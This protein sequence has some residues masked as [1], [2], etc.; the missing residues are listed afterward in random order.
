MTVIP[1]TD[2]SINYSRQPQ[3]AQVSTATAFVAG[4]AQKG[5]GD[6]CSV[7][8][9]V[10]ERVGRAARRPP[11]VQR[12]RV[13]RGGVRVQRRVSQL[14]FARYAGPSAAIASVAV[15]ASSSKFTASAKGPGDY[16]HTIY[17]GVA[18]GVITVYDGGTT[19]GVHRRD[20]PRPGGR[21]RRAGVGGRVERVHQHHPDRVRRAHRQRGARARR[22]FG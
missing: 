13:R 6:G 12:A 5:T 18:S 21:R 8:V 9:A 14:Y 3:A 15:P 22:G 16:A 20:Q 17:V 2:V 11:V 1:G 10:D 19:S 4:L 7:V